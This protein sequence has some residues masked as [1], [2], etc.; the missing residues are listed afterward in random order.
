MS[1][2]A[3]YKLSEVADDE[4]E[5]TSQ[6]EALAAPEQMY[7]KRVIEKSKAMRRFHQQ[8]RWRIANGKMAA[9]GSD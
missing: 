4:C 1:E 7:A 9:V 8:L 5:V 6:V 2:P 3:S